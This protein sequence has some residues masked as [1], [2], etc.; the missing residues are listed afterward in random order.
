[1]T[2][3]QVLGMAP[4][5]IATRGADYAKRELVTTFEASEDGRSLL[6][7]VRGGKE[8]HVRLTANE[9]GGLMASCDCPHAM[10]GAICKHLIASMLTATRSLGSGGDMDHKMA[11]HRRAILNQSGFEIPDERT[12][13]VGIDPGGDPLFAFYADDLMQEGE[14]VENR[15]PT[16]LRNF[17]GWHGRFGGLESER[18]FLD[19]MV[20]ESGQF[21]IKVLEGNKWID[22]IAEAPLI[23]SIGIDLIHEDRRVAVRQTVFEPG[24]NALND[25]R[26]LGKSLYFWEE[27]KR[28]LRPVIPDA[29]VNLLRAVESHA[30]PDDSALLE[31]T[32]D[33]HAVDGRARHCAID[34]WN[35]L[36]LPRPASTDPIRYFHHGDP[37]K[38]RL[39]T[40]EQGINLSPQGKEVRIDFRLSNGVRFSSAMLAFWEMYESM[41]EETRVRRLRVAGTKG[42]RRV[43][44]ACLW[45]MWH[46]PSTAVM[47]EVIEQTVRDEAFSG[48]AVRRALGG[49]LRDF[50]GTLAQRDHRMLVAADLSEAD[51]IAPWL[52]IPPLGRPAAGIIAGL[53]EQA[54][55]DFPEHSRDPRPAA[56]A[57]KLLSA[58]PTL[59][60]SCRAAKVPLTYDGRSIKP[61]AL[62][63]KVA[64]SAA[65][66]RVD[67]FELKPEV[68]CD[69]S[70]IPQAHWEEILKQ[71]HF[72][73]SD[74]QVRLVDL[75]SGAALRRF[76]RL[77]QQQQAES[78]TKDNP[79][80]PITVP[81]LR[82]FDWAAMQAEG[83]E[84]SLP[85]SEERVLKSLI[86]F[87][88][89]PKLELPEGLN[90][91]LR[92]YQKEGYDW[93]A[94]LYAHRFGACLAD[95]MGLG[96]T[97]QT[98]ALLLGLKTGAVLSEK[99]DAKLP[100][101]IVLPPTLL[102]NW[103]HELETFAPSITISEYSG[104]ERSESVF[105]ADVVLTSYEIVRRD[106][107]KLRERRFHVVVFDEAQAVKNLP[108]GRS[109]AVR[110]LKGRFTVCLTG[111]PLENHA[112]EYYAIL[113]LA[114]PGL[115]G[116]H[117]A[118]MAELK[119]PDGVQPL[120]RA[121]P[122]VLRRTK[123]HILK[124]LPPKV[125]SEVYL[126]MT[127]NQRA[128]YTRAV[129]EV[130]KEVL[131]AF[132]DHTAQQAGIVALAALTRL[133]QV[134]ISPAILDPK[135][136]EIAP[137]ISFLLDKLRELADEGHAVLVFSQF[138]R[139][140]DLLQH[141]LT[142]EKA[143]F[144]RIDGKTP[145]NKRKGIVDAFQSP[146]GAPVFLIS[147]K[148][149]GVGL[150]LT[151]AAYVMHLDP[152]WNPAVERQATDRAH[153]IGQRQTV[154]VNRL[155]MRH[156]VE[157]KIMELK[158]RKQALFEEV[159]GGADASK[160]TAGLITRD[161]M[162]W[163][164]T[165][166][167]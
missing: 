81:R 10:G 12:G 124:D 115:F 41:I 160:R 59:I 101:F 30:L 68:W 150:N 51:A 34:E 36:A 28:F 158:A 31:T 83:I 106:I 38:P 88:S 77:L 6:A 11:G 24:G 118:F 149:G 166:N 5:A 80:A 63:F 105:D 69:G 139:A 8:Y 14:T 60:E 120:R 113:E 133:R 147:L 89:L 137:K 17:C 49:L 15:L 82:I 67:W 71:G 154:F 146:E 104:K 116:S 76:Q 164:L 64:A 16:P 20:E 109:Q 111:T 43:L 143:R 155:L 119:E 35:M 112:G 40:P 62:H 152:W 84:C 103:R 61:A 65:P 136:N 161:D 58:L 18:N 42:R 19:W 21:P 128:Y 102:F 135:Y 121:K 74:G 98:I 44:G 90:A 92:P 48:L 93:L 140:L 70:L 46:A 131:E 156:S 144:L 55:A 153:R 114:L 145:S 26:S 86:E 56:P 151:R 47:R 167:G 85:E 2:P 23:C 27:G 50:A 110:Q 66:N 32:H 7:V 148:T 127:D 3:G 123:D 39:E 162:D 52:E 157:E 163:L 25:V 130:R 1:M 141:H 57:A 9:K 138:T 95:D 134:C 159:V 108:G 78:G 87:S 117:R 97:L 126:E 54:D 53:F 122:F 4:R 96:K 107:E 94:F 142:A 125:E 75:T 29:V 45:K 99:K 73:D 129:A 79:D 100:H 37:V 33:P 22:V 91:Q 72:I 132:S 13:F 165:T